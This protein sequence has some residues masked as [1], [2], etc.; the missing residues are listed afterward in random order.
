MESVHE[1]DRSEMI[2]II[3]EI[4]DERVNNEVTIDYNN[5]GSHPPRPAEAVEA[6]GGGGR[7]STAVGNGYTVIEPEEEEIDEDNEDVDL[8]ELEGKFCTSSSN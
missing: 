7:K 1:H 4:I 8:A 2:N 6:N 5:A 3:I